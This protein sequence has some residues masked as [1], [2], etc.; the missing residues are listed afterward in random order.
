MDTKPNPFSDIEHVFDRLRTQFEEASRSW[1]RGETPTFW[2]TG[3]DAMAVDLVDRDDELIATVDL[4]GF[5]RDDIEVKATEKSVHITADQREAIDEE[6]AT[7]L[8]RERRHR[9]VQ[10]TIPVPFEIDRE[11]VHATMTNGVL[12]ITLPKTERTDAISIDID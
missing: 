11:Q 2:P 10:R 6:E 5:D 4:P 7:Y 9:R 3:A 12:T 8:R 1:E